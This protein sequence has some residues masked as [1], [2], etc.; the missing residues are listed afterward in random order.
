MQEMRKSYKIVWS[1]KPQERV[2]LGNQGIEC[3]DVVRRHLD[4][5]MVQWRD[6]FNVVM[7]CLVP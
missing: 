3:D 7:N 5:D 2:H 6:L 1:E 4:Q